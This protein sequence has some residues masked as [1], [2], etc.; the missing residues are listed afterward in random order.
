[1]SANTQRDYKAEFKKFVLEQ[2]ALKPKIPIT[3]IIKKF[4]QKTKPSHYSHFP[5]NFELEEIIRTDIV[6]MVSL[7][8]QNADILHDSLK[9][10]INKEWQPQNFLEQKVE[11]IDRFLSEAMKATQDGK[12]EVAESK[13]K[14]LE[15]ILSEIKTTTRYE[16]IKQIIEMLYD[17]IESKRHQSA[18]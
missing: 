12:F 1:M 7:A 5:N 4:K 9:A 6:P 8:I 13:I 15:P 18:L 14:L 10:F 3:I 16:S 2:F 11:F 17:L